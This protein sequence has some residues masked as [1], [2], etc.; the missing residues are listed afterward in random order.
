MLASEAC[1]NSILLGFCREMNTDIESKTKV[2]SQLVNLFLEPIKCEI[3]VPFVGTQTALCLDNC[4][5]KKG[6]KL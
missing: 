4:I 1:S 6:F 3:K 2:S 5:Y